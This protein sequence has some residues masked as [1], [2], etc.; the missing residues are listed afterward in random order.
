[1]NRSEWLSIRNNGGNLS[2]FYRSRSRLVHK[3]CDAGMLPHPNN[4]S[5]PAIVP[6]VGRGETYNVGANAAK[7]EFRVGARKC[8]PVVR[9]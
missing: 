6:W 2:K 5:G 7:R 3:S 1:M 9:V 8:W 4:P